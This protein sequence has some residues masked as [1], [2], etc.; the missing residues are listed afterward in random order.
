MC[1]AQVTLIKAFAQLVGAV[2]AKN[3]E[4][5]RYFFGDKRQ[6][7]VI[8]SR[9]REWGTNELLEPTEMYALADAIATLAIYENKFHYYPPS[10]VGWVADKD[11]EFD[12]FI[13]L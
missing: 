4:F 6:C 9:A 13:G 11:A 5:S 7:E 12:K 2:V 3:E 1:H 8:R 10:Y